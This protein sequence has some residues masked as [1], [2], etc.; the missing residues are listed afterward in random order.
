MVA[1]YWVKILK[2]L[3]YC[4]GCVSHK[5]QVDINHRFATFS[6]ITNHYLVIKSI[7]YFIYSVLYRI[8]DDYLFEYLVILL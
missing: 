7:F 8:N 6:T 5:G 1:L 3:P 4:Y 2:L